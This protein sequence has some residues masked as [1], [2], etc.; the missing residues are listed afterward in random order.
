MPQDIPPTQPSSDLYEILADLLVRDDVSRDQLSKIFAAALQAIHAANAPAWLTGAAAPT[1]TAAQSQSFPPVID[2]GGQIYSFLNQ[3]INEQKSQ[4]TL[5][6]QETVLVDLKAIQ[7]QLATLLAPSN[8]THIALALPAMTR[9]G[10]AV[11]NFELNDD[12][13]YTV[14]ILTTNSAGTVEPMPAGDVFTVVSSNP[15]SLGMAI[16]ATASGAPALIL[17][18]LVAASPNITGTVSDSAGLIVAVQLFDIVADVSDT[19]IVLDLADATHVAQ[20]VPTAPGP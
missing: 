1:T 3:I 10:K 19:N 11:P 18:P 5:A 17:T 14:P 9:K 16:G 12:A 13:V 6:N 15:A 8:S 20:P 7:G 2:V 4:A